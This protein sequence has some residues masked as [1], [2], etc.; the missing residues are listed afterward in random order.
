M[1]GAAFNGF[2]VHADFDVPVEMRDGVRLRANI[3]RPVSE[4]L[5]PVIV[6]RMPYGKDFPLASS[7]LNPNI[8][9][10]QGFIVVIQDVRGRFTSEGTFTPFL[11]ERDDGYDTVEWAAQ[12][13]G[14][15]GNVG[16][17]G[18]SYMGFTQWAAAQTRPP[19][20]KA[21]FPSFTWADAMDG[22]SMRGGAVELG[23][24][25]NWTMQNAMDTDLRRAQLTGDPMQSYLSLR[26]MS[27]ELDTMPT[28]GYFE[29]PI[30]GFGRR[31]SM[32][33][34]DTFDE[35]VRRRADTDYTKL[36]GVAGSYDELDFPA[37][38]IAGW[39][40]IFLGGTIRNFTELTK[41]GKAPQKLMIG[42]WS[43]TEQGERIGAVDFGFASSMSFINLQI[44]FFSLQLRWFNRFLRNEPNGVD[45]EPPVQI[46][47][48]GAN[49]W[50][51]ENEWP[52]ARAVATPYYLHS[53]G[54]ANTLHGNGSLSTEK[55]LDEPSDTYIYDPANPTPTL[56]GALLMHPVFQGGPQD[57]RPVERRDDMLVFT[58][59]P[60]QEPVEV[61]G[62]ITVTLYAASDAPDTDF[63]ARLSDVHPDGFTRSLT[64]GI[65]RARM[66]NGLQNESLITPGQVYE[67]TIDLWA[68]S[69]LFLTGHRIRVDIASSNFPRWDRNLNTGGEYGEET[70]GK[71]A[72]Q[73]I[74]HNQQY[75][76]HILLPSVPAQ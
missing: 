9:A 28:H 71:P 30:T 73:T 10:R 5:F 8:A 6:M 76:S 26:K 43:H 47:V 11:N 45:A 16:M 69:N 12:L 49:T 70:S 19:H 36:S 29:T 44:D 18:A 54:S 37:Y 63:V 46:F 40:D 35:G 65:I 66:R 75:P 2:S 21:L 67:Y 41:R 53:G 55:P 68:T 14:S 31:R 58:S 74:L 52:L 13:P 72:K 34:F 42:P 20:L 32:D 59:E 22:A 51:Y 64:D 3:F 39:N 1:S 4:G 56:G 38:H 25:R 7:M 60:M 17:Y 24:T 23:I 33:Y 57:Q 61:T 27:G 62:P 15:N 48:M 50:R